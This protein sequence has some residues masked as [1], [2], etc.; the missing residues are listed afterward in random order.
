MLTNKLIKKSAD[1]V[2]ATNNIFTTISLFFTGL[3]AFVM[4][5]G[6]SLDKIFYAYLGWKFLM[7]VFLVVFF[8]FK[9]YELP[10]WLKMFIAYNSFFNGFAIG[11]PTEHF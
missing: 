8:Q 10:L 11:I 3:C 9:L 5:L 7:T 2:I 6:K 4:G 1:T